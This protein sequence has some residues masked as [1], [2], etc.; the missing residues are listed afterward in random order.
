LGLG[1]AG[2][3]RDKKP[4]KKHGN[5]PLQELIDTN[6]EVGAPSFR[7]PLAKTHRL[8]G[9]LLG[10]PK[11]TSKL[12]PMFKK[13]SFRAILTRNFHPSIKGKPAV[14]PDNPN[15]PEAV[16]ADSDLDK[17]EARKRIA[18]L[19]LESE[20]LKLE[21]TALRR[22]LSPPGTLM[23][24]LKAATV[25][26]AVLGAAIT[27][28][29]GFGQINQAEQN[30]NADRFDKA[31]TR[32]A[33]KESNERITGVSGLRLF[34]NDPKSNLQ[35][36]ALDFLV[37]AAAVESEPFV[38]S[39]ILDAF[40]DLNNV[41][42]TP[43]GLNEALQ[44]ALEDDRSLANTI[45]EQSRQQVLEAKRQLIARALK[46]PIENIPNPVPEKLIAR[47]SRSDYLDL[48]GLEKAKFDSL[49]PKFGVPMHGL[50]RLI[51]TLVKHGATNKDFSNIYCQGCDFTGAADLSGTSF[52][53]SYL[54]AADFSHVK[55]KGASFQNS[56]LR[57]VFFFSSDLSGATL[58]QGRTH[59]G[60]Y[61]GLS[62]SFPYLD[63]ADLR[64]ADLSG[65]SLLSVQEV[66]DTKWVGGRA[67]RVSA[68]RMLSAQIDN[69]TK[70]NRFVVV[71][72]TRITDQYVQMHPKDP[73]VTVL[74]AS[75]SGELGSPVLSGVFAPA[76]FYRFRGAFGIE[77]TGYAE[78]IYLQQS[79]VDKGSLQRLKPQ[80]TT[81]EGYLNQPPLMTLELI[82]EFENAVNP[83]IANP[84][85]PQ[86]QQSSAWVSPKTNYGCNDVKHPPSIALTVDSGLF[87][88]NIR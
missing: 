22:Q 57:G 23:E 16:A 65:T 67:F 18:K 83:K 12:E 38:Q 41:T 9:L 79:A 17:V 21:Q 68:P 52:D 71:S 85:Q 75:S 2:N 40:L 19:D 36:P 87:S 14:M 27:F 59:P 45:T 31:L 63:C 33:S 78:T 11:L 37:N 49:D 84:S 5:I 77:E 8:T 54:A 26:A 88:E 44:T 15:P 72:Y 29:V 4:P 58:T 32:L 1:D 20:K 70:L 6:L 64:G 86:A 80:M 82:K 30:R 43:L 69:K 28:Y 34:V 42:I 47:L 10:I 61:L 60:D 50:A 24:W 3:E 13:V 62:M 73:A 55:L 66:F 51:S 74:A 25:P 81:V 56:D 7:L 53:R 35:L 46:V 39:A 76:V 48:L